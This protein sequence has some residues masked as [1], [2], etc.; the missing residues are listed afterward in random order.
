[1]TST[2]LR[3]MSR[4]LVVSAAAV[5]LAVLLLGSWAFAAPHGA[6]GEVD[7]LLVRIWCEETD[8]ERCAEPIGPSAVDADARLVPERLLQQRCVQQDRAASAACLD[9]GA[10][11]GRMIPIV[12]TAAEGVRGMPEL[13]VRLHGGAVTGDVDASLARIRLVNVGLFLAVVSFAFVV[14]GP[15]VRP[16]MIATAVPLVPL[17]LALIVS[18]DPVA[19]TLTGASVTLPMLLTILGPESHGRRVAAGAVALVGALL[20]LTPPAQPPNRAAPLLALIG[21]IILAQQVTSRAHADERTIAA[22]AL[23]VLVLLSSVV[24]SLLPAPFLHP[25]S[26]AALRGLAEDGPQFLGRA[27]LALT[28]MLTVAALVMLAGLRRQGPFGWVLFGAAA[29]VGSILAVGTDVDA[30][31]TSTVGPDVFLPT[32]VV[33]VGV[34]TL[35]R[36]TTGPL[37]PGRAAHL[38]AG[39]VTVAHA[40]ALRGRIDRFVAPVDDRGGWPLRVEWWWDIPVGPD[41]VWVV[42]SL[43]MAGLAVLATPHL[44]EERSN[45]VPEVVR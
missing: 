18:L 3:A 26:D 30:I 19:W 15:R 4:S 2:P 16:M 8:F 12:V 31:S 1:M 9:T 6:V 14:A 43:A 22:F 28:I 10:M 25:A 40:F 23:V 35:T 45:P 39:V 38:L 42:G 29:T 17:G 37:L 11:S 7:E 36:S 34:A 5:A 20:L 24:R 33:L 13:Y 27:T 44:T 41:L 32:L 21:V